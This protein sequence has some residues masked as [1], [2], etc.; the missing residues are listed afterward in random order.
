MDCTTCQ[1]LKRTIRIHLEMLQDLSEDKQT[2]VNSSFETHNSEHWNVLGPTR[3]KGSQGD[4]L[5]K[6]MLNLETCH[7]QWTWPE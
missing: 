7:I 6:K 2:E 5:P 1:F 3:S 4:I